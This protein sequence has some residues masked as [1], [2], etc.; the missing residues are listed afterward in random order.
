M[1]AQRPWRF[2]VHLFGGGANGRTLELP[3]LC[4]QIVVYVD[5]DGLV[6]AG[7][8]PADLPST[9]VGYTY[10]LVEPVGPETPQYVTGTWS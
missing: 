4:P 2:R 3:E 6:A 5:G 7:L 1:A 9:R 8:N 10:R